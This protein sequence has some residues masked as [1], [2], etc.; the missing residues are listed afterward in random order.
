MLFLCS[1]KFDSQL[2]GEHARENLQ[3]PNAAVQEF[4]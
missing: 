3:K 4:E 2:C 1:E